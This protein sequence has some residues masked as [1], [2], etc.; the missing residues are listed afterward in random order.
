MKKTAWI[1]L[2]AVLVSVFA[3]CGNEAEP[4]GSWR[5]SDQTTAVTD[6]AREDTDP[7]EETTEA[8]T[9]QPEETTEPETTGP[10][11]T[12]PPETTTGPKETEPPE[13]TAVTTEVITTAAVTT[14]VPTTDVP[15]PGTAHVHAY[16][17]KTVA[18]TC[19][20]QGYTEYTCACGYSYVGDYTEPT[21]HTFKE[22]VVPPTCTEQGYTIFT[23]SCGLTYKDNFT[24]RQHSF[25]SDYVCT[26]CGEVDRSHA[27]E[28]LIK[29]LKKH[30][31]LNGN[32]YSF[33]YVDGSYQA[34]VVYDS[35]YNY[36]YVSIFDV[37]NTVDSR[38][39]DTYI[40]IDLSGKGS[41]TYAAYYGD[42]A[43]TCEGVI[44]GAVFSSKAK[45]E[46]TSYQGSQGKKTWFN[47]RI[48][49]MA[50]WTLSFLADFLS[51]CVPAINMKDLGFLNY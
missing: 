35:Q 8:D 25:N 24:E 51:Q 27:Y 16:K 11:E 17:K 39:D 2:I 6:S 36:A 41:D 30:G 20:E 14:A 12:E 46:M 5:V 18:P 40:L 49:E 7:P 29:Q 26:R 34:S 28:Y 33:D 45:L 44:D 10:K 43:Y 21:G 4:D 19:T 1:L 37:G 47:K 31:T 3:A 42:L 23:C 32:T 15:T 22:T 50:D 48:Q 13:T 9:T 38:D